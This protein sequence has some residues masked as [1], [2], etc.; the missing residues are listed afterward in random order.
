MHG[1]KHSTRGST[2]GAP[3]FAEG[4]VARC[5]EVG[6][7]GPAR[8]RS[9]HA[10]R[11]ACAPQARPSSSEPATQAV[12][13]VADLQV[14]QSVEQGAHTPPVLANVPLGHEAPARGR[15]SAGGSGQGLVVTLCV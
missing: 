12:H 4:H 3:A 2:A 6:G 1:R 5:G 11:P 13:E 8:G 10:L 15:R 14:L 7:V 9:L